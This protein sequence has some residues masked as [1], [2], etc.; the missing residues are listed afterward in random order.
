M[1][2]LTKPQVIKAHKSTSSQGFT[3]LELMIVVALV[4][5]LSVIG[6]SYFNKQLN[7]AKRGDAVNALLRAAA[8]MQQ[9]Y[10]FQVPHS[11]EGCTLSNLGS[12]PCSDKNKASGDTTIYSP[13][14]AW[15]LN[16]GT[17]SRNRYILTATRSYKNEDGNTQVETLTLDNLNRK[18]GPWPR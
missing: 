17:P 14:C 13:H 6:W 18:T 12:G 3:L 9:C 4:G 1:I 11:Y 5:I 2:Y 8:Q 16:N 10:G 15:Q 7:D